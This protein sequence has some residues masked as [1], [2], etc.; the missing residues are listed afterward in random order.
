[1]TGALAAL[2]ANAS[3][4]ISVRELGDVAQARGAVTP[5][6]LVYVAHPPAQPWRE[7]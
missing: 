3:L 2:A 6:Q 7:T 5:R 4:E 1:M